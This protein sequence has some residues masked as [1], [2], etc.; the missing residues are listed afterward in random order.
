VQEQGNKVAIKEQFS[1]AKRTFLQFWR[2]CDC[3]TNM[4]MKRYKAAV[5]AHVAKADPL[6]EPIDKSMLTVVEGI[7]CEISVGGVQ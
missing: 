2:E 7:C 5:I 4:V 1:L 6:P 3:L